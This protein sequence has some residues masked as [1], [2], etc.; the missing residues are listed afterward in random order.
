MAVGREVAEGYVVDLACLRKYPRGELLERAKVHTRECALMPHC[1]ESGYGLVDEHGRL[2]VL[3]SEA[4]LRV[5]D[6]LR[7]SDHDR[8]IRVRATRETQDGEM[9]TRDVELL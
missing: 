1:V 9:R 8:G 3:D 2:T 6:A 7:G 5:Y 4:T